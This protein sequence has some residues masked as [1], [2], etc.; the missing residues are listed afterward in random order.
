MG[1]SPTATKEKNNNKN[2][3]RSSDDD[4]NDNK[5]YNINEFGDKVYKKKTSYRTPRANNNATKSQ[6]QS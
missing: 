6:K 1:T 2:I 5:T 3:S 4:D